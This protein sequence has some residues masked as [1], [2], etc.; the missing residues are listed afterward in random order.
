MGSLEGVHLSSGAGAVRVVISAARAAL[1][2]R[3]NANVKF[4]Y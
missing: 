1:G 2:Q 3:F 4:D